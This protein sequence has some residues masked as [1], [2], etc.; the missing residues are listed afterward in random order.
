MG[1]ASPNPRRHSA[2]EMNLS[3]T[4]IDTA[5]CLIEAPGLRILT[6]PVFDPPGGLYHHGWGAF[7]RKVSK[8]A[9]KPEELGRLDLVL[10][11]HHQHKD[12]LDG[13]GR[14]VLESAPAIVS[15]PAAAQKLP[16]CQGLKP[17]E[18]TSI[19]TDT[20]TV[21]ITGT[22]CRHHPRFLPEFFSGTVTGFIIQWPALERA[23]YISGDTVFFPPLHR[24]AEQFKIG[25]ALLHVGKASF[26]YITGAGKYT[27]DSRDYIR[28]IDSITPEVAIPIH[29]GGWTHFRENNDSLSKAL[30]GRPDIASRTF[31][32]ESGVAHSFALT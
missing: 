16:H 2:E 14:R 1:S 10:L 3:I 17:F 13:I 29:N 19:H 4:H 7:S 22:P 31:F 25:V 8:P 12:N 24:I 32:P 21:T 30:A 9:L 26:P 20:G 11:S 27:M 18:S 23:L 15:T 28:C 5:C 6:D